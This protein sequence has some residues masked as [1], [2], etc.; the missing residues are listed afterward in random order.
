MDELYNTLIK[1]LQALILHDDTDDVEGELLAEYAKD[2]TDIWE[3]NMERRLDKVVDQGI[4]KH[5]RD[6]NPDPSTLDERGMQDLIKWS[7][8]DPIEV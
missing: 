6:R 7:Q 1:T 8:G 5:L 4:L 2:L 3:A